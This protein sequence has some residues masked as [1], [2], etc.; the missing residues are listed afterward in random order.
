MNDRRQHGED[1]H[2]GIQGLDGDCGDRGERGPQ[3]RKG[4]PGFDG[5]CCAG[6]VRLMER[7]ENN[8]EKIDREIVDRDKRADVNEK[9]INRETMDRKAEVELL[10]SKIDLI[11]K[12]IDSMKTQALI[13]TITSMVSILLFVGTVLAHI[14]KIGP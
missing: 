3:G 5:E 12:R 7:C 6:L 4:I 11:N 8:E 13:V 1:R 2:R 10:F 9:I 14:L